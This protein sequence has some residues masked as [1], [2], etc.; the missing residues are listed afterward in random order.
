MS[1]SFS[2]TD[3][4]NLLKLCQLT[5]KRLERLSAAIKADDVEPGLQDPEHVREVAERLLLRGCGLLHLWKAPRVR[6]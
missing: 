3:L 1:E 4:N 6:L 2:Q 5:A